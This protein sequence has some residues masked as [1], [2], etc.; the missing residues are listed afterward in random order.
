MAGAASNSG[1]WMNDLEEWFERRV[2]CLI[3]PNW[4]KLAFRLCPARL[5]A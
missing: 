3:E 5:S 1:T 4:P 2:G